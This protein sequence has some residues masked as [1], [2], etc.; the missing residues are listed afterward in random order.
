MKFDVCVIGSGAGGALCAYGLQKR[1]FN[2]LI[3]EKGA[4]AKQGLSIITAFTN[5]YRDQGFIGSF[6]NT[7]IGI[8]T[9]E[10][11]GG[12]T[13]INS[14]TCFNT[15]AEVL[16]DWNKR[17]NINIGYEDLEPHVDELTKLLS[18]AP[19]EQKYVAP[20]NR[21][22]VQGLENSGFKNHFPLLRTGRNCHGSGRCCFVCPEEAKQSTDIAI[23]PAF[24][25]LGGNLL[26]ETEVTH[27]QEDKNA[28]TLWCK[29]KEKKQKIK[30]S[31]LIIAGGSLSSPI[32]IRK[33]QIGTSYQQAGTGLTI[34]P[35]TKVFAMFKEP[36][37]GWHGVPQAIGFK[38]PDFPTLSFEGVFTPPSLSGLV[39]PLEA[40]RLDSWLQHYDSVASFGVMVKDTLSGTVRSLPGLG[41][42]IRYHLHQ[43]D[44]KNLLEAVRFMGLC[45][46]KAGAQKVLLPLNG[47]QNEF[48]SLE[49]LKNFDFS[50]VKPS[51][52]YSMGFHPLG[53]CGMGRVVD[54]H[55]K[56]FGSDRIYVADGSSVPTSLGVNPQMTI[57]SLALRLAQELQ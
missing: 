13:K 25:N 32:L 3:L 15:P 9:G 14:G 51:Q 1:G 45:Y 8:P 31:K 39:M 41:L 22:F 49:T 21:L 40:E 50:S 23:I 33:N 2:T 17:L 44:F 10:V 37:H 48:H 54:D 29:N 57:M 34:H 6:G 4:W 46:L 43:E 35:A 16:L 24:L 55:L 18:I 20:G 42:F 36:I 7:Y 38:H 28:V 53:T 12:T 11:V 27:I 52:L 26:C 47:V 19:V 5:Y 30:C 56:V